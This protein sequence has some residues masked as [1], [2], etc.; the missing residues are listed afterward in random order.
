MWNLMWR[1]M[2]LLL[3]SHLGESHVR[4]VIIQDVECD[5][6]ALS[7]N[8]IERWIMI[9]PHDVTSIR[10]FQRPQR[11]KQVFGEIE[12]VPWYSAHRLAW[13]QIL[14]RLVATE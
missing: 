6:S 4:A 9:K 5:D 12:A 3:K 14:D 2:T 11:L 10:I 8:T 13:H 7:V 1:S